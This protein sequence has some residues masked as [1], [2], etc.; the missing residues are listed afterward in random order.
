MIG[1]FPVALMLLRFFY[2]TVPVQDF[3]QFSMGVFNKDARI[4]PSL[5]KPESPERGTG[6]WGREINHGILAYIETICVS[7]KYQRQGLGRWAIDN[8]LKSEALAVCISTD[9][10]LWVYLF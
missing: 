7:P 5:Y 9:G 1:F 4:K 2:P 3:L 8:L 10:S 6:V